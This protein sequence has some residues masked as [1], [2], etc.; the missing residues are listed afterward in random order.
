MVVSGESGVVYK[1][2][3]KTKNGSD[4]VAIKTVKGLHNL[5]H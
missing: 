5:G 3:L 4:L 2:I 1:A